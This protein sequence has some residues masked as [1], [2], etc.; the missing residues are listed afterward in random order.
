MRQNKKANMKSKNTTSKFILLFTML[1]LASLLVIPTAFA[2]SSSV[3]AYWIDGTVG[4]S[5]TIVQNEETSFQIFVT[6]YN[7]YD[8][9]VELQDDTGAQVEQY[10]SSTN[11]AF[12]TILN[13]ASGYS[14]SSDEWTISQDITQT[15]GDYVVYVETDTTSTTL[16]LEVLAD[17]DGDGTADEDDLCE[18]Y[19]DEVDTDGD[20]TPDGCDEYTVIT[21]D[22]TV[23]EGSSAT[24]TI[25]V[26]NPNDDEGETFEIRAT[27]GFFN[28]LSVDSVTTDHATDTSNVI[29]EYQDN[30]DGT[31]E[32]TITPDYD[33][34][35][36]NNYPD[37][38]DTF[39]V[40]GYVVEFN[41]DNSHPVGH[42]EYFEFEVTVTDTNRDPS[43]TDFC[44]ITITEDSIDFYSITSVVEDEDSDDL[45][46]SEYGTTESWVTVNDDG[47]IDFD[48]TDNFDAFND[49]P[50]YTF[51]VL[52]EDYYPGT[53]TSTGGQER[54]SCTI[55]VENT[56]RP[57]TLTLPADQEVLEGET[58]NVSGSWE[59]LDVDIILV[60]VSGID[61]TT[62]NNGDGTGEIE[63]YWETTQG[64]AGTYTVTVDITDSEETTTGTFL[65]TVLADS[66]GDG[67]TDDDDICEGYDDT[68]D[69]DGD[70]V[71]D[72]CDLCEGS[73]DTIDSDADG[74]PDG[75][76]NAPVVTGTS[77]TV[78]VTEGETVSEEIYYT[79]DDGVS[80]IMPVTIDTDLP[81]A[82]TVTDDSDADADET[83]TITIDWTTTVGDEGTYYII[84][85]A[86]D[87]TNTDDH[88]IEIIVEEET[89]TDASP[90]IE[91]IDDQEI[92]EGE[93]IDEITVTVS[94]TEDDAS[95]LTITTSTLPSTM[96]YTDN[97]DGTA[98]INWE[99][100]CEDAGTYQITITVTDSAG[101]TAT[102]DFTIEVADDPTC[103][104]STNT[105]PVISS[106]DD[107]EITEG[108][109]LT[110]DDIAYGDAED[111]SEDLT[112]T[113]SGLPEAATCTNNGDGTASITLETSCED[114]AE[115]QITVTVTD[116]TGA[117]SE[118]SFKLTIIDNPTCGE[119]TNTDPTISE[120]DNL[121][122]SE[123]DSS[124]ITVLVSDADGDDLTVTIVGLPGIDSTATYDSVGATVEI[125]IGTECG[126]AGTYDVIIT[127]DDGT[128]T[129]TET[130]TITVEESEEC[131]E[132]E[133]GT[134]PYI[135]ADDQ[136]VIAGETLEF[137][138]NVVEVD[139]DEITFT[140][141]NL[142]TAAQIEICEDD[143]F[144]ICISW[145]T[146]SED[147]GSY[148][149]EFTA[150]DED[151][152]TTSEITITVTNPDTITS[153]HGT[154]ART[155][156]SNVRFENEEVR[157][158]DYALLNVALENDG[159]I[160]LD[161]MQV[162]VI[163][164]NLGRKFV[165]SSFNLD[166]GES[167]SV[168]VPVYVP[169][170]AS[171]REYL[172][173][174]TVSND[175]YSHKTYRELRVI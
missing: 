80:T 129:T 143:D 90:E 50:T 138:V 75:C 140:Y 47:L 39:T 83:G 118:S 24:T 98:T 55:T 3:N 132:V 12:D 48:L 86:D 52:I 101:N 51:D 45:L 160:D 93:S 97:G 57:A 172:V 89:T 70:G 146:T 137:E 168:Q 23:A 96:S 122:I 17:S 6:G 104:E 33:L 126:D 58:V 127:A 156:Y 74:I 175:D 144:K 166:E 120:T 16:N 41:D 13:A 103:S 21:T 106:I 56:N 36:H 171:G 173:Q 1:I 42:Q 158:G 99:T 105:I 63:F 170:Y 9:L 60:S 44:E 161:D 73:D 67:V 40:S 111:S 142:P 46:Y 94:D 148:E 117:S 72:G 108:D 91:E 65:I 4:D 76:D 147:I 153:K 95:D 2:S 115:Y 100:N 92:T 87:G 31:F 18:G 88:T 128:T 157:A 38:D 116:T 59:D 149:V 163:I 37:L 19:D 29:F 130:F 109:T 64:D 34:I 54:V 150:S 110:I 167:T 165:S 22:L 14:Y 162:S 53:T 77:T 66:D 145:E 5:A 164:P 125:F 102:E 154:L 11:R 107:Q 84:V 152:T 133:D 28:V 131:T 49:G 135:Y 113:T 79:D 119:E 30:E 78:T 15:P 114:S 139:G 26:D 121:S 25:T 81:A 61:Y 8:I 151:G 7:R 62:Q 27:S 20:G 155:V 136:T 123:G 35:Y 43:Q 85:T 68:E 159:Y 69:S 141:G 134:R 71:P 32:I 82:A 124:E 112:L 10:E 174:I 169:S